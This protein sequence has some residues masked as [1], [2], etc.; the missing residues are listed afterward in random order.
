MKYILIA[1]PNDN[2]RDVIDSSFKEDYIIHVA[3]TFTRCLTIFRER[4]YEYI[5]LDL[6]LLKISIKQE[7]I[8]KFS[9]HFGDF[10]PAL[11][12]LFYVPPGL[13]EKLFTL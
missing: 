12:S 7:I 2:A 1:T 5:F 6:E 10:F 3:S 8:K 11:K 9:S 13:L 4:R